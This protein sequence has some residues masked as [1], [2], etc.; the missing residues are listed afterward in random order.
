[1]FSTWG[2]NC[3]TYINGKQREPIA[4]VQ[5]KKRIAQLKHMVNMKS[6]ILNAPTRYNLYRNENAEIN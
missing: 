1:M 6:S 3:A 2:F 4:N 5:T